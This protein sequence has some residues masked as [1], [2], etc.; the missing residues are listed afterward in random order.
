[1]QIVGLTPTPIHIQGWL[2]AL[3]HDKTLLVHAAAQAQR[4]TDYILN[5]TY[6]PTD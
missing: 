3:K 1:M 2:K 5:V 4:S 6:S